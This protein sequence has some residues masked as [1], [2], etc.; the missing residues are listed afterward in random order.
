M[1]NQKSISS[2]IRTAKK[3]VSM[4]WGSRTSW[5]YSRPWKLFDLDGPVTEIQSDSYWSALGKRRGTMAA[6]AVVVLGGDDEQVMLADGYVSNGYDVAEA[7]QK[8]MTAGSV[9]RNVL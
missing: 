9:P 8:A 5:I 3:H 2:A 4:P 6:I 1:T 7:V